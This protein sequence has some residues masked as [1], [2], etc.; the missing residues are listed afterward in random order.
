VPVEHRA[1]ALEELMVCLTVPLEAFH[2]ILDWG[3]WSAADL[4]SVA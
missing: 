2:L 1:A 4:A 3:Q